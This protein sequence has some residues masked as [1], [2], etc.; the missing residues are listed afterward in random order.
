MRST[1]CAALV[2]GGIVNSAFGGVDADATGFSDY[3]DWLSAGNLP[4]GTAEDGSLFAPS[5][6]T[7]LHTENF[8]GLATGSF[9]SVSNG[10]SAN[11]WAWSAASNTGGMTVGD[12]AAGRFIA[13]NYSGS[14]MTFSFTGASSTSAGFSSGLR[15]VGG[16]F[17]FYDASG[18]AINGRLRLTLSDGASVVRN[19]GSDESFA[20]FWLTAP[21]LTITSL[22]IEPFGSFS[23]TR[24][25]GAHTL[26]LGYAG[27]EIPAPGA[28]ALLGAAGLIGS[29]RRRA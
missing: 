18:N 3:G 27:V 15:G 14:G 8:D 17:R 13:S 20:G 19:F 11:W 28:I 5:L 16:G 23:G 9:G 22:T 29:V 10:T 1:L 25:V 7:L 6:S 24:F 2:L 21:D 26:Y 4:G 12:N